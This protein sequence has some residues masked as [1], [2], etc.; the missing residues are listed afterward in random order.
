MLRF[1]FHVVPAVFAASLISTHAFDGRRQGFILGGGLGPSFNSYSFKESFR[2]Y[3]R[4]NVPGLGVD[5]RIG[6]GLNSRFLLMYYGNFNLFNGNNGR[7]RGFSGNDVIGGIGFFV[8]L[9]DDSV[10]APSP[11]LLGGIGI[12]VWT[13]PEIRDSSGSLVYSNG[14]DLGEPAT[15]TAFTFGVGYEFVKHWS[16][17]LDLTKADCSQVNGWA[18]PPYSFDVKSYAVQLKL[19]ALAY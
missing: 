15:G 18:G 6:V 14:G 16:V 13:V 17:Q 10:F 3:P 7:V 5:E 4:Q 12:G 8:Y 19:M 1:K 2:S 11:Y 9:K